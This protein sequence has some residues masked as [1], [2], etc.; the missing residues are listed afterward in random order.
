MVYILIYTNIDFS[1][2]EGFEDMWKFEIKKSYQDKNSYVD[3]P[4]GIRADEVLKDVITEDGK[5]DLSDVSISKSMGASVA[6]R[7]QDNRVV[8]TA[9]CI[10]MDCPI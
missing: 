3:T 7:T 8:A 9:V 1:I 10:E 2:I 5:Y 4:D 6:R